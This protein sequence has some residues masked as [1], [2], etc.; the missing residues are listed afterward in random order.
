MHKYF[1]YK[2]CNTLIDLIIDYFKSTISLISRNIRD[3]AMYV[4]ALVVIYGIEV[5]CKTILL[6]ST[7]LDLM[8]L[9]Y[10]KKYSHY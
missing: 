2:A 7:S 9:T 10:R 6:G 5:K 1:A 8:N 3:I 4:L